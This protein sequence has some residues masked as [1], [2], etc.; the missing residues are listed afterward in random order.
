MSELYDDTYF[1]SRLMLVEEAVPHLTDGMA[2]Y[3]L[4]MDNKRA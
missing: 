4:N 2:E 3:E 1:L